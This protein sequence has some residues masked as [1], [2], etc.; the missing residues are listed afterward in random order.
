[1]SR[2]SPAGASFLATLTPQPLNAQPEG[3]DAE[4]RL[5]QGSNKKAEQSNL[6]E[7]LKIN[8]QGVLLRNK[9]DLPVHCQG[10]GHGKGN[11]R[12]SYRN[13]RYS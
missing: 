2:S 5:R 11:P 8:I 7:F 9:T 1:V 10:R 4:E 6:S 3:G 12:I 13:K